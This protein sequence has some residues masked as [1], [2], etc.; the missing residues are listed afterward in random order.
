[1]LQH[2][3]AEMTTAGAAY[4]RGGGLDQIGERFLN[5]ASAGLV[6]RSNGGP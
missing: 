5:R 4:M 3:S 2:L 6:C 1:M